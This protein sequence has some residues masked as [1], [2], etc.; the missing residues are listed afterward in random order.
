MPC[1]TLAADLDLDRLAEP[2]RAAHPGL[3]DR[4]DAIVLP[5][6]HPGQEMAREG[7]EQIDRLDLAAALV[8]E[9]GAQQVVAAAGRSA[10]GPRIATP[11]PITIQSGTAVGAAVGRARHAHP[12]DHAAVDLEPVRPAEGHRDHR[13][14]Q[15]AERIAEPEHRD[16]D[17]RQ[18]GLER[19][20]RRQHH[21]AFAGVLADAPEQRAGLGA[22]AR[23]RSSARSNGSSS[24]VTANG[25]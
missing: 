15:A 25:R 24:G 8:G 16:Q 6:V 19:L 5:A 22:L 20:L 12:A 9:R 14:H 17:D 21:G 13:R 10:Q 3:Q 23:R 18:R 1:R 4:A 7:L 2:G 11:K